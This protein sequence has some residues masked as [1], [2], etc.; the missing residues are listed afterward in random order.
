MK[1]TLAKRLILSGLFIAI[2]VVL[3]LAFHA[4]EGAGNIFLPMHIPVLISGF[5]LDWPFALVIGILTPFL[6]SLITGMPPFFPVMVFMI[7]ELAIYGVMVS[8][9]YRK[10]EKSIYISLIISMI[11]GRIVAGIIVWILT[12]FFMV[13][14]PKPIIFIKG[15]IIKGLPGIIIQLIF[16][17]IVVFAIE[18]SNLSREIN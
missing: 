14:L 8:L 15:A 4:V 18:K 3:P 10:Y 9:L 1:N 16:I 6:S 12:T 17:P 5:F 2:G 13:Q 11:C 7:F